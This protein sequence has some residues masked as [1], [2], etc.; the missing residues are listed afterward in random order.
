MSVCVCVCWSHSWC[1][2]PV[3]QSEAWGGASHSHFGIYGY[4]IV[5][6]MSPLSSLY[7][8][9]V[10]MCFPRQPPPPYRGWENRDPL[11]EHRPPDSR[12]QRSTPAVTSPHCCI[13]VLIKGWRNADVHSSGR[14]IRERQYCNSYTTNKNV[15]KLLKT[16]S[17]RNILVWSYISAI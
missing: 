8:R 4:H 15:L 14:L 10:W 6:N 3:P 16:C 9:T 7:S 5:P 11:C 1:L 13:I 12:G 2:A 17:W